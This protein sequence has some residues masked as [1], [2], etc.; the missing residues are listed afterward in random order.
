DKIIKIDHVGFKSYISELSDVTNVEIN[1]LT[2]LEK[3]LEK[4]IDYFAEKGCRIADHGLDE[5]VFTRNFSNA[6][7]VFIKVLTNQSLSLEEITAFKSHILI[8][9]GRLYAK[10]QWVMQLHIG[11]LRNNNSRL[12]KVLG[13]DAGF[14]SI[15]DKNYAP[16]LSAFLDTLDSD[17]LL[18][19]TILYSLNPRDNEMIGTMIGNFQGSIPGKIQYGSGWWFNDQKDG[20]IRQLI[21]LSSLGLL[22]RFVGML[23]DSRSFLSFSRHEYFR[24]ILC[25]LIGTWVE[26]QELANDIDFL[27]KI[28]QDISFNNAKDYFNVSSST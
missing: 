19:K 13:A 28:V 7:E 25:N 2:D 21:A 16:M 27:G 10:H 6:G 24:R 26:D 12:F 18:P 8:T 9:M 15:N 11:A 23:T 1:T 17:D 20:M 4:R 22:P 5:F 3:A 14:D